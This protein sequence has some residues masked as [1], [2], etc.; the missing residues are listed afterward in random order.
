MGLVDVSQYIADSDGD[1]YGNDAFI[2]DYCYAPLGYV[3]Y[4]P[5]DEVDCNDNDIEVNP[6]VPASAE[7]CNGRLDSC[8]NQ[9]NG[10]SPPVE[11]I[12][13]DGDGFV[14]CVLDVDPV[15]WLGDSILGDGDCEDD[16]PDAYPGAEEIRNGIAEDCDN[17][18]YGGSPGA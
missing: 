18:F 14:A 16:N 1:G 12:D 17:P 8:D 4:D 3:A 9:W 5:S 2:L 7:I 10:V 11:E 15:A 6:S 13:A